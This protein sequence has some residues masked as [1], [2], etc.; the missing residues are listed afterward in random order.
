MNDTLKELWDSLTDEQKE[1]AQACKTSDELLKLAGE[2]GIELPDEVLDAVA[3]GYIYRTTR[4]YYNDRP[5]QVVDDETGKVL[6]KDLE[7]LNAESRAKELGVSW[8]EITKE[9]LDALKGPLTEAAT[10]DC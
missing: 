9:Q 1:K 7:K 3:G 10:E 6:A 2:E 4:S 8:A 5:Y